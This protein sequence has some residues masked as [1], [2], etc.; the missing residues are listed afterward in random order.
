MTF[1]MDKQ[2]GPSLYSTG[3]SIQSVGLDHA[4]RQYEKKNIC[5]CVCV[6]VCVCI[7]ICVYIYIYI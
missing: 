5:V 7:Y 3:N 4:G 2:W 1:R 6:C